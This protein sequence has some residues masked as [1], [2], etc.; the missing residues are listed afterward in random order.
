MKSITLQ[1]SP[2]C[3]RAIKTVAKL[4]RHLYP[5]L[6]DP[7][8]VLEALGQRARLFFG[9]GGRV[10]G[11]LDLAIEGEQRC[12]EVAVG[13]RSL[14]ELAAP[15]LVVTED[16]DDVTVS[17]NGVRRSAKP[18]FS[19]DSFAISVGQL[20][21]TAELL[22]DP[23]G[24]AAWVS[25]AIGSKAERELRPMLGCMRL[26]LFY[27]SHIRAESTDTYRLHEALIPI[28]TERRAKFE[29][30]VDATTFRFVL[31][32]A[33]TMGRPISMVSSEEAVQIR[34]PGMTATIACEFGTWPPT[35]EVWPAFESCGHVR[36]A[37][38]EKR[39]R[40][41]VRPIP[42]SRRSIRLELRREGSSMH[43]LDKF[44]QV[45]TAGIS[46]VL[47]WNRDDLDLEFD[48]AFLC[49]ALAANEE[50]EIHATEPDK[51]IVVMAGARKALVMPRYERRR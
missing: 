42:P 45:A 25:R 15:S 38:L 51:P 26:T 20:A 34:A 30:I 40:Q 47:S 37:R 14:A 17:A 49:D 46:D 2:A 6:S 33:E 28:E 10:S 11:S 16:G 36:A 9:A 50:A 7:P 32:I 21:T 23:A 27:D 18:P 13:A 5:A 48:P 39:I 8:V 44:D 29:N 4:A 41:L 31:E 43:A 19:I 1:L 3:R 24:S 22:G 35:D 12:P